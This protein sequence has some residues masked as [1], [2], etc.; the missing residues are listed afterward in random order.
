MGWP[1][2]CT[3]PTRPTNKVSLNIYISCHLHFYYKSNPE[4]HCCYKFY[5]VVPNKY[6]NEN[7]RSFY[8]LCI[9]NS[10]PPAARP[11]YASLEALQLTIHFVSMIRAPSFT[12]ILTGPDLQLLGATKMCRPLSVTTNVGNDNSLLFCC[13]YLLQ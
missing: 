4:G 2:P 9:R 1:A 8:S 13:S 3:P 5:G 10:A 11:P 6:L 12:H 7:A